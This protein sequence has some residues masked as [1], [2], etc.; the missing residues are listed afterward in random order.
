[1][2]FVELKIFTRQFVYEKGTILPYTK[3][4]TKLENIAPLFLTVAIV[5]WRGFPMRILGG[6]TLS[7]RQLLECVTPL[8]N[9]DL[10]G[11][12]VVALPVVAD[13]R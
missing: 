9:G 7:L 10:G 13:R 3:T 1:L 8:Q 4:N 11:F 6:I 2:Y 12:A 5:L